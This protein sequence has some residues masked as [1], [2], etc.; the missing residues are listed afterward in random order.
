MLRLQEQTDDSDRLSSMDAHGA[1]GYRAHSSRSK[2][3]ALR[4]GFISR[5]RPNSRRPPET[6]ATARKADAR[7]H[8]HASEREVET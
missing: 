4:T 3:V 1:V 8:G 5:P 7:T 6:R 2:S